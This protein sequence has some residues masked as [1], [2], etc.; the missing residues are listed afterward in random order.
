M[1]DF[2]TVLILGGC[3]VNR[4][5]AQAIRSTWILSLGAPELAFFR[6]TSSMTKLSRME[7]LFGWA[8]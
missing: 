6:R 1:L 2:P 7:M 3:V 5:F 4:A 8:D